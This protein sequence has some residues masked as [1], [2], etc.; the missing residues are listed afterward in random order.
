MPSKALI[1]AASAAAAARDAGRFGVHTGP[2][3]V[4]FAAV[5][6]HVR[7][8]VTTIAETDSPEAL[9]RRGPTY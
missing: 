2:V 6:A 4:D 8:A 9:R 3:R 1:A 5:V 7:G